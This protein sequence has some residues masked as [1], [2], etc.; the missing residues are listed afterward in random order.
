MNMGNLVS[1]LFLLVLGAALTAAFQGQRVFVGALVVGGILT[2]I[3]LVQVLVNA[4][5]SRA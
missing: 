2:V 4:V 5:R 1:G 3:G